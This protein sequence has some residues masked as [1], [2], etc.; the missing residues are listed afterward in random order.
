M[1][2]SG[3]K[4]VYYIEAK[5]SHLLNALTALLEKIHIDGAVICESGGMRGLV[6]PSLMI[7]LNKSGQSE[8]KDGFVKLSPLA[9]R[10]V[11]FDGKG[12]NIQSEEISFD[13]ERWHLH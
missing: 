8:T 9:N 12:F 3:A 13:G 5:D 6:E 2:L 7:L 11:L 4:K 10:I 1:L